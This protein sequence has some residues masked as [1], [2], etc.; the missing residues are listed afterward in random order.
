MIVDWTFFAFPLNLLLASIWMVGW[1]WLYRSRRDGFLIRFML[2]PASTIL[3]IVLLLAS[4]FW[5]G[6]SGNRDFVQ[7][8]VFV[9][10]LLYLQ[11][12]LFLV[13]IRGWRRPD[14]VIRWRFIMLHAGLLLALGAGYWGAPDSYELR[15]ALEKGES[16]REAY[17]FD[18]QKDGLS[19]ELKLID[20]EA[21]Y[22]IDHKPMHYEAIVSVDGSEP[23]K[24]RVNHP[25]AVSLG[26]ELYLTSV[27]DN[28]C[29]LQIVHEPWRYMGLVGILM[30]MAGAVM[31]FLKG[32][33]R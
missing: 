33:R 32:P 12:V 16:V 27:S 3:S 24:I 18:G 8:F 9:A 21:R 31:L 19:Y 14:G 2:S 15:A 10:L 13:L 26:E 25:Y 20:S 7:S 30:L 22:S 5:I 23:V 1:S 11:T 29:V 6:L 4:C 28:G 17:R